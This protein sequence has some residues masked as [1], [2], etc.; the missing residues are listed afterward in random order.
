MRNHPLATLRF[1]CFLAAAGIA[2][3]ADVNSSSAAAARA[4]ALEVR[5]PDGGWAISIDEVWRMDN[6]LVVVAKASRPPG[7]LGAR[8]ICTMGDEV[9]GPFPELPTRFVLIGRNWDTAATGTDACVDEK[10]E[11]YRNRRKGERL[12]KRRT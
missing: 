5:V 4:I 3:A 6:Q 2:H 1:V 10:S 7:L 11:L 9:S 12:W 8:M